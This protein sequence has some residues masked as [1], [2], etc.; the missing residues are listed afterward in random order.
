MDKL[1]VRKEIDLCKRYNVPENISVRSCDG[2]YLVVAREHAN[3]IVLE[4]EQQLQF[5]E[6]LQS[7]SLGE[8]LEVFSGEKKDAVAVVTQLEAKRFEAANIQPLGGDQQAFL[9]TSPQNAICNALIAICMLEKKRR[10]SF[11]FMK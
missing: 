4:N 5:F 10:V 8:A 2:V 3:W 1:K 7:Y 6:L 9:S 11:H